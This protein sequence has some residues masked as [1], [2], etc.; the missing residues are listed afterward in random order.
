M[1]ERQGAEGAKGR[2]PGGGSVSRAHIVPPIGP[3]VVRAGDLF[4]RTECVELRFSR[5]KWGEIFLFFVGG[6]LR[7][8]GP[9]IARG[10]R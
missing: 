5:G 6:G 7:A 8:E 10:W 9:G 3:E 1:D 2:T 4:W